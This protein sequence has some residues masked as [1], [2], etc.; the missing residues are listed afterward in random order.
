MVYSQ[1]LLQQLT[2]EILKEKIPD[3]YLFRPEDSTSSFSLEEMTG[4]DKAVFSVSF[5]ANLTPEY[6]KEKIKQDLVGKIPAVGQ[7]YLDDLPGVV[8]S[9]VSFQP[10]FPSKI[11]TFPRKAE[12][13]QVEVRIK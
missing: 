6:D 4:D 13:I 9:E 7:G 12:N 5:S 10:Q 2:D 11:M 3:N 1:S 8:G